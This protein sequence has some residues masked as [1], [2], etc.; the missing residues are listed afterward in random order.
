MRQFYQPLRA[1]PSLIRP[2][3]IPPPR[4]QFRAFTTT[5]AL[6]RDHDVAGVKDHYVT[7]KVAHNASPADIKKSFYALSKAHHPDHNPNDP[8][9]ATK[10]HAISEAYAT[11][12][13]PAKRAAYD[14]DHARRNPSHH[15][16]HGH[17]N[18]G[19]YHSSSPA[20]GRPA[21]GL[22]RRKTAFR[23]P[24]PSF[25]RSGGWGTQSEKRQAAHDDSIGGTGA[26][27]EGTRP[28]A[29]SAEPGMGPGQDP[30][31][32][33]R[34]ADVPH[35]DREGH[36]RTQRTQ[37]SRRRTR[38]EGQGVMPTGSTDSTIGMFFAVSGILFLTFFLP[39]VFLGGLTQ[40]RKRKKEEE[41][42]RARAK[43]QAV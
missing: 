4:P 19:S 28:A 37:D 14:R 23:G 32:H 39:Y 27:P 3:A 17:H 35:F 15:H 5:R 29:A 31:G 20:G 38:M 41:R 33:R 26:T 25:Y 24:P 1:A 13:T 2:G 34:E 36:A 42:E 16:H 21:S 10:F 8:T 9:A 11:L 12:G 43:A 40:N 30:Y 7:L 22:S 6:R 18:R